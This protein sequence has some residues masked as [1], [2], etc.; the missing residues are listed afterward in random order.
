MLSRRGAAAHGAGAEPDDGN[1][2]A[3][4]HDG[5]G[6]RQR[7]GR[8]GAVHRGNVANRAGAVNQDERTSAG[9]RAPSKILTSI[10]RA[11]RGRHGGYFSR[12]SRSRPSCAT[13]ATSV[14]SRV[15]MR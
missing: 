11:E 15:K 8:G 3:L 14:P 1:G 7:L 2:G 12:R 13:D 6:G 5:G 4:R 9:A 10:R